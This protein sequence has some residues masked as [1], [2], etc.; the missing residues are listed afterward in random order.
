MAFNGDYQQLAAA[1]IAQYGAVAAAAVP[2]PAP[3]PVAKYG[4]DRMDVERMESHVAKWLSDN[5]VDTNA[6]LLQNVRLPMDHVSNV[7]KDKVAMYEMRGDMER[8]SPDAA[9]QTRSLRQSLVCAK[10]TMMLIRT[11]KLLAAISGPGVLNTCLRKLLLAVFTRAAASW[12]QDGAW[13]RIHYRWRWWRR[14]VLPRH[15]RNRGWRRSP[16]C[17]LASS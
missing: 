14:R 6:T 11:G 9:T 12:H 5:C 10:R 8:L 1:L 16:I 15:V 17:F 4:G 13:Q 2:P 3:A 7:Y